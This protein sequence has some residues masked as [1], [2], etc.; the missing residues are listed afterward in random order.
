MAQASDVLQVLIQAIKDSGNFNIIK[1]EELRY[2]D[3]PFAASSEFIGSIISIQKELLESLTAVEQTQCNSP[4]ELEYKKYQVT[5]H[6][7]LFSQLHSLLQFWEIG[8]REYVPEFLA[9]LIG[10]KLKLLNKDVRYI[11]LP[12]YDYNYAYLEILAPLKDLLTDAVSDIDKSL[13]FAEKLAIFWFPLAHRDNMLL[14]SLLGHELGHFVNEEKAIVDRLVNKITI[15]PSEI[16]SIAFEWLRARVKAE[17]KDF[18]MDDYFGLES[19]KSQV[20]MDITSKIAEQLKELVSDAVGFYMFGPTFLMA[21]YVF[22]SSL[23]N[24]GKKPKGYPTGKVRIQFLVDLFEHSGYHKMFREKQEEFRREQEKKPEERTGPNV[25]AEFLRYYEGVK[26][27]VRT[28]V[29]LEDG[30]EEKVVNRAIQSLKRRVWS[31]VLR[32]VKGQIYQPEV[33]ATDV[34]RLIDV[35]DSVVPPS[36]ID[37]EQPANTISI[38]NAGMLYEVAAIDRMHDYFKDKTTQERLATRNKLHKIIMKAGELSQIQSTLQQAEQNN[39]E[40]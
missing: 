39:Q 20:K 32:A 1:F 15:S 12:T 6:G 26:N 17:K 36:E 9:H 3:Y 30:T 4:D 27:D 7:Q 10:N 11:F 34:F 5:R 29:I 19:V 22:L 23:S 2:R 31:S 37:F 28:C 35:I 33:F 25:S 40:S 13:K 18:K 8:G 24:L 38:M 14:N 21:Q 16:E